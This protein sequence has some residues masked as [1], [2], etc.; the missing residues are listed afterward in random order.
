MEL[1]KETIL[2]KTHYGIN[3]YAHILRQYYSNAVLSL[4]G[5]DCKPINNPFNENKPTLKIRIVNNCAEHFDLENND[6]KGNVFDFAAIHFN[7]EGDALNQKLNEELH[8]KIG[9]K[10]GFYK[11]H[12]V[13]P[14]ALPKNH[15]PTFSYFKAPVTNILPQKEVNLLQ[16]YRVL[17]GNDFAEVTTALRKIT[18][19]QEA[20]KYKASKLDYVTFSGTFSKRSD[21]SLLK[22]SGLITIDFDH[23]D[24]ISELKDQLLRDEYFE[25]ELLFTSPSGDGLKWVLP[26]DLTKAKHQD[27]FRAIANYIKHTY[28]LEVDQS[29]KD[30]SRACFLPHDSNAFINPKYLQ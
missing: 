11:E 27:Y 6:F 22:H 18:D 14:P 3:I 19:K 10:T 21:K 5:R 17:I 12:K 4:S 26:L 1:N 29:G 15:I 16:V 13:E 28:R 20:K 23:V 9:K 30:I 2:N 25:T 24:N 7:L 8:L